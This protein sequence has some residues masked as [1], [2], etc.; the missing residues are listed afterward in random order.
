MNAVSQTRSQGMPVQPSH[1]EL[2]LAE[3]SNSAAAIALLRQYRPYLEIVPSLR[4]P[5]ESVLPIP[6]P[7]I[8]VRHTLTQTDLQTTRRP[9][10]EAVRLSCDVALLMCDPE[11]Q[12]KTGAEILIFIHRPHEDFSDLLGRWRQAQVLLEKD[13]EWLLPHRY[14]HIFSDSADQVYPLFV[15]L[16][17]TPERIKRGLQG[18]S[19]PFVVQSLS[20]PLL[21]TEITEINSLPTEGISIMDNWGEISS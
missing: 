8:R 12:I 9:L 6:L 17:V 18:A 16:P 7:V 11:W 4:R 2:L 15:I 21:S 13:Y 1:Y 10:R 14:Q 5:N 20:S 19:L 3:Y